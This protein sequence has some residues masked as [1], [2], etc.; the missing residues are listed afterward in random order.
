MIGEFGMVRTA[1]ASDLRARRLEVRVQDDF[2]Q[3]PDADTTVA[4]RHNYIRECDA[5]ICIVGRRSGSVPLCAA[6]PY[7][8]SLP[9]GFDVG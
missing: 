7:P 6:R 5:V 9:P 4:K 1:L 2:R 8:A 3:E